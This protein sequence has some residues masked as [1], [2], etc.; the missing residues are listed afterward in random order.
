LYLK[1][2]LSCFTTTTTYSSKADLEKCQYCKWKGGKEAAY[3]NLDSK[4][5]KMQ[6]QTLKL[7]LAMTD[8]EKTSWSK[9]NNLSLTF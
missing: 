4:A 9:L 6:H 1:D 2:V 5:S 3:E 8:R 7:T